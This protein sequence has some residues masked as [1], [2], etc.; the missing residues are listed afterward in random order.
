MGSSF[1]GYSLPKLQE[2]KLTFFRGVV[3]RVDSYT[4][5]HYDL[6]LSANEDGR[7]NIERMYGH[8]LISELQGE[9]KVHV[10]AADFGKA[11]ELLYQFKGTLPPSASMAHI[12]IKTKKN[13]DWF[14][15][16][17]VLKLGQSLDNLGKDFD[18][19][20][21][22]YPNSDKGQVLMATRDKS[23]E[24]AIFKSGLMFLA[25]P[26]MQE[27]ILHLKEYGSQSR[28]T[29]MYKDDVFDSNFAITII[30]ETIEDIP[31]TE[32]TLE[33][34]KLVSEVTQQPISDI[35]IGVPE[36]AASLRVLFL[37]FSSDSVWIRTWW[38]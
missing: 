8:K 23:S 21:L 27:N 28:K 32:E 17:D 30:H 9:L 1:F 2:T 22:L 25:D 13:D 15:Q 3:V 6:F 24:V 18:A 38:S 5:E 10:K 36:D 31:T 11:Q 26:N 29:L 33:N 4:D 19:S 37:T 14:D 7:P 20:I 34:L 35:L 16:H 12:N